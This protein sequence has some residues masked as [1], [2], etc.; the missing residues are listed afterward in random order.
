MKNKITLSN[1][2]TINNKK[3]TELTYD[4]NEITAQMFAEADSR[5]LTASG[6]KN[7]NAAG[8]AELDYGLHLYLGFEAIIAVNPEIDMSDLERVHGYD[9][10]HKPRINGVELSGDLTAEELGITSDQHYTHKQ[11][12]AAK[13]WTITHGLGKRPSVTVVDSAGTAVIGEIE[14]LD[15]NTVRLTFCAAFSGTAYCN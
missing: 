2:L 3:R 12:Q 1:P 13:V 6:S 4:A 11:A 8:A 15:D 5:K 9:V 7:G 14:Y 10:M